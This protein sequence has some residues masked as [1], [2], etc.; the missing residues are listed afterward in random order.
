[1]K[2]KEHIRT[3]TYTKGEAKELKISSERKKINEN[4]RRRCRRECF[5]NFMSECVCCEAENVCARVFMSVSARA[6]LFEECRPSIVN[7]VVN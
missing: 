7:N 4:R 2:R 1:M 3:H 6:I 5:N